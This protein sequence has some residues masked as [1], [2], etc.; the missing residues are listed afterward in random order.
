MNRD[1]YNNVDAVQSLA[2]A[3]RTATANGTGVDLSGY[4]SAMAEITLGTWT[5]GTHTFEVQES[6]DNSTYTAVAD[7]DLQGTEPVMDA[8]DEDLTIHRI[9]YLG[10]KRYLRVIATVA[11]AT[12][13]AVY[14]ANILRGH[15]RHAP[16]N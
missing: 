2:P 6:D 9:G 16:V 11:S 4:L 8:A 15:P 10:T 7:A 12:T 1:L 5:D 14:G 3:G 13:G